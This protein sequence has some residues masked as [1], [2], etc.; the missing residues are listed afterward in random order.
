M[1]EEG[2]GKEGTRGS[3]GRQGEGKGEKQGAGSVTWMEY[4][5][6]QEY[7]LYEEARGY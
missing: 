1:I 2:G 4:S 3:G 6:K 5:E 7:N